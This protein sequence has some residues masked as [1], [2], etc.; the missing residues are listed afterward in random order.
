M[1]TIFELLDIEVTDDFSAVK[2]A[3]HKKVVEIHPDKDRT[4]PNAT[5]TFR[6]M[7]EAWQRVDSQ[8][9][10]TSYCQDIAQQQQATQEQREQKSM[11]G[12]REAAS[13]Q[14]MTTMFNTVLSPITPKFKVDKMLDLLEQN[15]PALTYFTTVLRRTSPKLT[16]QEFIRL[17]NI[18][19]T[20]NVLITLH[21]MLNRLRG[22][23]IEALAIALMSNST[24]NI[25]DLSS[26]FLQDQGAKAIATLLVNNTSLEQLSLRGTI[27]YTDGFVALAESLKLNNSLRLLH[28]G[29][30]AMTL[31]MVADRERPIADKTT[32]AQ[33]IGEA[34]KINTALQILFLGGN[35]LDE[36]GILYI[37]EALISNHTLKVLHLD[38]N[39]F[40]DD[41][42]LH[43]AHAL[44]VN[45]TLE[46]LNIENNVVGNAGMHA[47]VNALKTN[48]SLKK[49]NIAGNPIHNDALQALEDMLAT[50]YT[51]THVEGLMGSHLDAIII[52]RLERNQKIANILDDLKSGNIFPDDVDATYQHLIE[53]VPTL[54]DLNNTLPDTHPLVE[55]CR[56]LN[57]LKRQGTETSSST[58]T[59]NP[60][61]EEPDSTNLENE[62]D[63]PKKM[64]P[65]T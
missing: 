64:K 50:N 60:R 36:T 65:K 51:L 13:Y 12:Q 59:V 47:I 53:L 20:N 25:L 54:S 32:A 52:G 44:T 21:L 42:A 56:L 61:Q 10:L 33:A 8:A 45:N 18:L 9:K 43:L 16:D 28:L 58:S 40:H 24:L 37:S 38:Q 14:R 6:V 48:T 34:L 2:R 31:K 4:N 63:A 23:K 49:I 46:E 5:D 15:D 30:N 3:Y 11:Q 62:S 55:G 7:N 29:S 17:L 41:G 27:I 19:K 35:S 57:A 39:Y 22:E 26:N 1:K